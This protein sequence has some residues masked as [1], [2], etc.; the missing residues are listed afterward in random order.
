MPDRAGA[1][2]YSANGLTK[3]AADPN[4]LGKSE[5]APALLLN[6]LHGD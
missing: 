6:L 4:Y 3:P 2:L 5:Q 1:A